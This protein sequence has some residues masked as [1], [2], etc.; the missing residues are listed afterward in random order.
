MST[1]WLKRLARWLPL[2]SVVAMI[3]LGSFAL[4]LQGS[5]GQHLSRAIVWELSRNLNRTVRL[6]ESD[7]TIIPVA[8][9]AGE[10][11][12][13]PL[14]RVELHDLFIEESQAPG[15]QPV[16]A[17][18][19]IPEIEVD[20]ALK[21]LL[22][23]RSSTSLREIRLFS[24]HIRLLRDPQGR[25]NFEDLLVSRPGRPA[26][27]SA[28]LQVLSG[29]VTFRDLAPP[30]ALGSSQENHLENL[31]LTLCINR[32]LVKGESIE[33]F[34]SEYQ[35]RLS[36]D[37]P[38][39]RLA[40]L[41][42]T[43]RVHTYGS[44]ESPNVYQKINGSA[45]LSGADLGY[46]WQYGAFSPEIE[47]HQGQGE[48]TGSFVR[49]KRPGAAALV[50]YAVALSGSD[51]ALSLPWVD[52]RI[53][54]VSGDAVIANGLLRLSGVEAAIGDSRL[55]GGGHLLLAEGQEATSG[56]EEPATPATARGVTYAF[57]FKSEALDNRAIARLLPETLATEVAQRPAQAAARVS[58][59]GQGDQPVIY[60]N[61]FSRRV[62]AA[63]LVEP[64]AARTE[65][66]VSDD[67]EKLSGRFIYSHGTATASLQARALKGG[68]EAAVVVPQSG[69][70]E[71]AVALSGLH[72]PQTRVASGAE[73]G[74]HLWGNVAAA[75]PLPAAGDKF[76]PTVYADVSLTEG[77]LKADLSDRYT[78]DLKLSRVAA[79][80]V[81]RD[82]EIWLSK[83]QAQTDYGLFRLTGRR[84][85][86]G[87]M[88]AYLEAKALDL[89]R[90]GNDFGQP[91][92]GTS[93][94]SAEFLGTINDPHLLVRNDTFSG[95][96]R[97]YEF[98]WLGA[99]VGLNDRE[100]SD[101]EI[102]FQRGSGEGRVGG[103]AR[104]PGKGDP[105]LI[106]A[107]GTIEKARLSQWL[108]NGIREE[109]R[110]ILDAQF[111][112]GGSFASPNV[113]ATL[114]LLRPSFAG[115]QFDRAMGEAYYADSRFTLSNFEA[116]DNGSR[117]LASGEITPA[118]ELD[119]T[120]SAERL[121]LASLLHRGRQLPADGWLSLEGRL[122]GTQ[123]LPQLQVDLV[124]D[125]L[126]YASRPIGNVAGAFSWNGSYLLL[127]DLAY[128]ARG[129]RVV[130]NGRVQPSQPASGDRAWQ[131]DLRADVAGMEIGFLLNLVETGLRAAQGETES[132]NALRT[133][134][135]IPRPLQ[136]RLTAD[137]SMRGPLGEPQIA[138]EFVITDASLLGEKL[139][140][141]EGDIAFSSP[142]LVVNSFSAREAE[143]EGNIDG[144]VEFG[145]ETELNADI[146]NLRAEILRPW[147]PEIS[148]LQG[149][150]DV[151]LLVSGATA[152]PEIR[153][154]MEVAQPVIGEVAFERLKIDRFLYA[155]NLL[156][157]DN[158][159][160][161]KGP[162]VARFSCRVPY[163]LAGGKLLTQAPLSARLLLQEQDLAF[164][165]AL[166]PG[167]GEMNGPLEV[168]LAIG[169]TAAQPMLENGYL[170][171]EGTW[172]QAPRQ[173]QLAVSSYVEDGTLHLQAGD[174]SPGLLVA[175]EEL[176][177]ATAV[178]VGQ[179]RGEGYYNPFA[180]A[181]SRWGRGRY[182]LSLQ[183]ENLY[184][185]FKDI[186]EGRADFDLLFTGEPGA[187]REDNIA[188][189]ILVRTADIGTPSGG[190]GE[191][192]SWLPAFSPFLDIVLEARD[193]EVSTL[194][195]R[196]ELY[197]G[198]T[199]G[200]RLGYEPLGLDIT[201][202]AK[203]GALDFPTAVAEVSGME[204]DIDKAP[205]GPLYAT[206][207]LEATAR[208]GRYRI[209]LAGG[210]QLYP[211]GEELRIEAKSSPPLSQ[212]QA[213]ALLLGI[214][215]SA[216]AGGS[217]A[218]AALGGRVA[219]SL[220][221]SVTSLAVAGLSAPLLRAIGLN[222]LSFAI[223]PVSTRLQLGK[224]ILDDLYI[225]YLS[226]LSGEQESSILRIIY[227]ISPDLSL[228]LTTNEQEQ[229]LY[230]LQ[231]T[232]TF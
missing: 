182:E 143:A 152:N 115:V 205:G 71:A 128:A 217:P 63:D 215:P 139:P 118:G 119:F 64:L 18:L 29:R 77:R 23:F 164:I 67:I 36:G 9:T 134:Q 202:K 108:P 65:E 173:A 226:T 155:D 201:L 195:A 138:A 207:Q 8:V 127:Q 163:D 96:Y 25:W 30:A 31:N 179:L 197:G 5:F 72:L 111:D 230:E 171:A 33:E 19:R 140:H 228:A 100:I 129:G 93:F 123:K 113:A 89:G 53:E 43:G 45:V 10:K 87:V 17:L 232:R 16:E 145:G 82:G 51:M 86:Q 174:G 95:H 199:I 104:L 126:S 130:F 200:G 136:G 55:R 151:Y 192:F 124:A 74:G 183:A 47:L 220:S 56:R 79:E 99:A 122:A 191:G 206:A 189:N 13:P 59:A 161:V 132:S 14:V 57:D 70:A 15:G 204:V 216:L 150:A 225:Y 76:R 208:V 85:S 227:D 142:R 231:T 187:E 42:V 22:K 158:L 176:R 178:E 44:L 188:G 162:H 4:R 180:G 21:E 168:D 58:V 194:T 117:L 229:L 52:G 98:D 32:Y 24:P 120:F 157:V 28:R 169:G 35:A 81:Y 210:G 166:F 54:A 50:D 107:Q 2:I 156:E 175:L 221:S 153:G 212:E 39:N 165:A 92:D 190:G 222:E 177:G 34:H 102:V 1:K 49:E 121:R 160:I 218:E 167:V 38:E 146:H 148:V 105:G 147:I 62:Q 40:G 181:R 125:D 48:I 159:R 172:T 3:A 137:V 154:D 184:A 186:V 109:A 196:V 211:P 90:I 6:G 88:E 219:N 135:A 73:V 131:S 60:G 224:R 209:D 94:V 84:N 106:A 193:V 37:N 144:Y 46:L 12:T 223:T 97:G 170:R 141:L 68:L 78:T 66:A 214:P 101:F 91:I 75:A 213:T 26:A 114:E 7:L 116:H 185:K 27:L 11:T 103:Y 80:G 133:V 69:R 198:G 149:S 20:L 203:R 110:G 41:L 61:L 112:I 83:A